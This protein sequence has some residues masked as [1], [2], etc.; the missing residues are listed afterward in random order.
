MDPLLVLVNPEQDLLLAIYLEGMDHA[1]GHQNPHRR[2]YQTLV[3]R[4]ALL[5]LVLGLDLDLA[6]YM[7]LHSSLLLLVLYH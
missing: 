4:L 6:L 2:K 7:Y 3:V 1:L 5:A